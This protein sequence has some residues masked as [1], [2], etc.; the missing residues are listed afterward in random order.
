MSAKCLKNPSEVCI[1][2]QM[3]SKFMRFAFDLQHFKF[4]SFLEDAHSSMTIMVLKGFP[5]KLGNN[6]FSAF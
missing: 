6:F 3:L 1:I 5:Q 2:S 4:S